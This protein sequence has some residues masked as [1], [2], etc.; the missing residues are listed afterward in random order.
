MKKARTDASEC[1]VTSSSSSTTTV[2]SSIVAASTWSNGLPRCI[3]ESVAS[4]CTRREQIDIIDNVCKRWNQIS[5]AADGVLSRVWNTIDLMI[6]CEGSVQKQQY[7]GCLLHK[8][9]D[10]LGQQRLNRIQCLQSVLH[11]D[12]FM[13]LHNPDR[14]PNLTD[15]RLYPQDGSQDEPLDFLLTLTTLQ[16]LSVS[17]IS[18]DNNTPIPVLHIPTSVRNLKLWHGSRQ[19]QYG[20]YNPFDDI[21]MWIIDSK[22]C[23]DSITSFEVGN[24]I[25]VAA[26]VPC[27]QSLDIRFVGNAVWPQ[28]MDLLHRC[29]ST[30]TQLHCYQSALCLIRE[31]LVCLPA[32]KTFEIALDPLYYDGRTKIASLDYLKTNFPSITYLHFHSTQHT[33]WN[34]IFEHLLCGTIAGLQKLRKLKFVNTEYT[35]R[36]ITGVNSMTTHLVGKASKLPLKNVTLDLTG[37]SLDESFRRKWDFTKPSHVLLW[38]TRIE[39]WTS[40]QAETLTSTP[41]QVTPEQDHD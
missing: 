4:Y 27:L 7:L 20:D 13:L 38:T 8:F 1:V 11:R 12:D 32:L 29:A 10:R 18:D 22:T 16:S 19:E 30:L 25:V 24:Q 33:D 17:H 2:T 34:I 36:P 9:I 31:Q 28:T 41:T 35:S 21:S 5:R 37:M 26:P 3:V 6:R 40:K 15:L 23:L 14:F 39:E